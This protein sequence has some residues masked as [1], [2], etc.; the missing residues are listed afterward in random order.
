MRL[1]HFPFLIITLIRAHRFLS[2]AGIDS[3]KTD[4][5]FMVDAFDDADDR[6]RY[7]KA[8]QD[9]WLIS[10]LRFFSTKAISCN[11]V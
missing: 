3:V 7:I 10:S 9:A 4:A 5:Q 2:N 1:F 8:Y 11:S 6:R